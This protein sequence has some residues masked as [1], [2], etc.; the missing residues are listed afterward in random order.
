MIAHVVPVTRLR[1]DTSWWSYAIPAR[2]PLLPGCLVTVPFRGRA[3]LGVV[4]AIDESDGKATESI[5]AVLTHTPLVLAPH[6]RLIEDM[7]EQ[8]LCSLSTALYVWLPAALRGLPLSPTIRKALAAHDSYAMPDPL[9]APA[10]HAVL[11]PSK[12]PESIRVVSD[13]LGARMA[14]LFADCTPIQELEQW[15]RIARG[16]VVLG[17]GRER[18]LF[19]PWLNLRQLTV[20][21]PEDIAY[22]REQVPYLDL[23]GLAR[24]L[25]AHAGSATR[26]RSSLPTTG[27]QAIWGEQAEGCDDWPTQLEI[28]DLTK[29]DILSEPLLALL[30]S[31]IKDEKKALLL[32]NAHD[33]LTPDQDGLGS[34][35]LPGIETLRKRLAHALEFPVLP[36]SIVLD[37]RAML[38]Y[39]HSNVGMTAVLSLDPLL[40]QS[41]FADH[42]HGCAD[43]GHLFSHAAPCIVQSRR[44]DH[45]LVQALRNHRLDE[46]VSGLADQQQ[47]AGLPPFGEQLV[48]SH[49]LE[50]GEE[51]TKRLYE[52]LLPLTESPWQVSFPFNGH[53]R[54]ISYVHVM[55]SA[56]AG[57]RLGAGIR[58]AASS[59]KRPWRVQ[60]NPRHIM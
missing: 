41:V 57:T 46:Y 31:C 3:T 30:R 37:T 34:K 23:V 53:W 51:A 50:G 2:Q 48:C 4:W 52:Q 22:Y 1:R 26:L 27:A 55:L 7:A 60:R 20:I 25:G 29:D 6:R 40:A 18:S 24:N 5:S 13:R 45:P 44:L 17:M 36:E 12:R 15:L 19:A 39:P 32:Y 47:A 42:L 56:P 14:D 49:P 28:V 54:R 8:G 10:Q 43:L 21:E 11:L 58:K 16:E 9:S 35:L 33:R 59:L 38:A